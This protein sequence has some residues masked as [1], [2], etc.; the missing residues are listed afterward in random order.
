MTDDKRIA[1]VIAAYNEQQHIAE[2]IIKTKKYVEHVIVVDDGSTDD[3]SIVAKEAGALV[4]THSINL[5]KGSAV[6]TGCDFAEKKEFEKIILI[7]ADGQHNP[8]EIPQFIQALQNH[9]VVFGFRK[10]NKTMPFLL[11]FGNQ[12]INLTTR[13]LYKMNMQD[14]QCGYRAMTM[15]SYQKIKWLAGDYSMESEMIANVGRSNLSFAEVPIQTIYSDK[16]KGTTVIDGFKI[17]FNM[18]LWRLRR[19]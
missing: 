1:A 4:L 8:D 2:V 7:D 12:V 16:Y 10:F 18:M 13:L 11:K 14:T 6:K 15:D 3:T 5:G 17:V 19:Q 9:D